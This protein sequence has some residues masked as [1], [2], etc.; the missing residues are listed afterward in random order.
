MAVSA[1]HRVVQH[2]RRTALLQSS[3]FLNDSDLL[4]RFIDKQDEA[5]YAILLRR[6]GP[7]V[8]GVCKRI[9]G[10]AHDAEDA[11]Q[12]TFLVLVRKAASITPRTQVGNWLHGVARITALRAKTAA[13]KRQIKETAWA[14]TERTADSSLWH[15]LL[16]L[17]DDELAR[18]PNKY[19]NPIVLCDLEN[20]TIR[21]AAGQLGWPP[22]TVA[23]RLA[24]GR[25]MLARRL[26]RHGMVLSGGLVASLLA[27]HATAAVP[28]SLIS[29]LSAEACCLAK[30]QCA[31]IGLVSSHV[32]ILTEGVVRAMT[33]SKLRLGAALL[34]VCLIGLGAGMSLCAGYA[35]EP[36]SGGQG[37]AAAVVHSDENK[38]PVLSDLPFLGAF[39]RYRTQVERKFEMQPESVE[40]YTTYLADIQVSSRKRE[41]ATVRLAEPKLIVREN[42]EGSF[43]SGKEEFI[44][45]DRPGTVV[46]IQLGVK[47]VFKVCE[48][49]DGRLRVECSLTYSEMEKFAQDRFEIKCRTTKP[50]RWVK[51]GETIDLTVDGEDGKTYSAQIKIVD[52]QFVTIS[53]RTAK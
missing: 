21:D 52:Q 17:L 27:R 32:R 45:G 31:S 4:T 19:R 16:P 34:L 5:A 48:W 47:F 1:F 11:F 20:T 28:I 12:A 8:L 10:N 23:G 13:Q 49:N 44:P 33:L 7:M 35:A 2:A 42:Q 30:E 39:F 3:T 14:K 36:A 38:I 53:R 40:R 50:I 9:L 24:R 18:L 22:G 25:K 41:G 43:F 29:A 26:T 51:L 37:N 46:P 15:D 6:H